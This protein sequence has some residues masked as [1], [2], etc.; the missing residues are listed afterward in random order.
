MIDNK[1]VRIAHVEKALVDMIHFHRSKYSVDLVIEKLKEYQDSLD[2]ERLNEFIGKMS[3][4]TIKIFGLIFDLLCID[5]SCLY[6]L[7][8][9]KNGTLKML[10][11]DTKFNSKWRLYYDEYFD[12]YREG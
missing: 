2:M 7:V 11:D 6:G 8:G 5:S 12:K 10:S 4:V 9:E 3:T 1:A